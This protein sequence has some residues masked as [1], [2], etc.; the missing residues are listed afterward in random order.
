MVGVQGIEPCGVKDQWGYNPSRL[1]S[2]LY[3]HKMVGMEGIEPTQATK[4]TDFTD[5]PACLNG[6][7]PHNWQAKSP[8]PGL[9]EGLQ[10]TPPSKDKG[11]RAYMIDLSDVCGDIV[12]G[13][14]V[15]HGTGPGC[16]QNSV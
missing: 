2:G 14:R 5:P 6:L 3:A 11:T 16:Y 10:N 12:S 15:F 4:D 7:H 8:Y 13:E 1:H 9:P